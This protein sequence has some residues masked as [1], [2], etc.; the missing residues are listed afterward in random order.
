M[1]SYDATALFPSVPIS[2]ATK[3]IHDLLSNDDTLNSRTKL[4][5]DEICDL[6]SLCLSS[7][8]FIYNK[9]HHTQKDSGPIGLSLMVTVS[10]IWMIDTMEKATKVAQTRG[11][12]VPRLTFIYM[13]DCWCL[14]PYRRPGLRNSPSSQS[15]P[16]ADFNDCLNS[17][18]ERVQFTRE[19]EEEKSIAFLD[20][21]ITREDN[22]KLSTS[23]YRKPSNTNLTMKPNSCQHPNTAIATFKGEI[24]RAYRLCTS[25]EQARKEIEFTINLFED[26]GHSRKTLEDIARTYTPPSNE[27]KDSSTNRKNNNKNKHK[28]DNNK[29]THIENLF[30]VLPFR[31]EDLSEEEYKPFVVMTYL[32]DGTYHQVKRACDKAGIALV[33]KS[34]PKLKDVL[35]GPNKTHHDP[36]QKPGVYKLSCPCKPEAT[37]VGQTIRPI[38]TRGKEHQRAAEKGNWHH[39]GITQHKESCQ[40]E[41]NWEPE[42]ITTMQNKNKKKLTRDLKVRE[43]LEIRRHNCGPGHGLN[44]DYGAYVRT[45]MWNPVF[46]TMDNG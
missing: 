38:A 39:S 4:N 24:C 33:T 40:E 15:D 3:L 43:A 9:R 28:A 6:I 30:D 32:P 31:E 34:G 42:V 41:V 8:N 13:D 45:T 1:V 19:E 2:D 21:Y 29:E 27:N 11:Y 16:A 46:H 14:I 10:Q 18:H 7:S 37:Y 25:E 20:V 17:I 22:N 35:C 44:E 26:N 23:I 36:I 12:T 5:P